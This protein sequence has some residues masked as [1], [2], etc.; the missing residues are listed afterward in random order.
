MRK[1]NN[2]AIEK[3]ESVLSQKQRNHHF[4]ENIN[5][6]RRILLRV[7]ILAGNLIV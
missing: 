4:Q 2:I 6:N 7:S 5:I 1:Y 3:I